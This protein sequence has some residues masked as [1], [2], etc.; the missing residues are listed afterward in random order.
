MPTKG[1]VDYEEGGVVC[2]KWEARLVG[3]I[4]GNHM[5]QVLSLGVEMGQVIPGASRVGHIRSAGPV[6]VLVTDEQA[7]R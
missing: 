7:A 1:V 5:E 2:G 3:R 6:C 4:Y